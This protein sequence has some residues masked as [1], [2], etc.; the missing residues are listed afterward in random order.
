[1]PIYPRLCHTL[2]LQAPSQAHALQF[3]E[4]R[5]SFMK[6]PMDTCKLGTAPLVCVAD[7]VAFTLHLLD[8]NARYRHMH[9][10]DYSANRLTWH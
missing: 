9:V 10:I 7:L 8:Q 2:S 1:M 5:Q 6:I 4:A 3:Q